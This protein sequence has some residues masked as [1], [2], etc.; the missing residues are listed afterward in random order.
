MNAAAQ[1]KVQRLQAALSVLGDADAVEKENPERAL[2]R[3]RTKGFIEWE[4]KRLAAAEEAVIAAVQNRV[5]SLD[6]RPSGGRAGSSHPR[7]P[8]SSHRVESD[9]DEGSRA[10]GRDDSF[11]TSDDEFRSRVALGEGRFAPH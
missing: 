11:G 9:A 1:T 3:A 8:Q 4:K 2:S 5:V 10:D 6:G 7:R